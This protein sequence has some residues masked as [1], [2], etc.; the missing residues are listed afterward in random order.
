M[1]PECLMRSRVAVK[2]CKQGAALAPGSG[3]DTEAPGP[4]QGEAGCPQPCPMSRGATPGAALGEGA[5][6]V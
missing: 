6:G 4:A 2:R 3:A 1:E 5:A